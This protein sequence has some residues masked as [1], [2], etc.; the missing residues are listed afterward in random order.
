MFGDVMEN[1]SS[2]MKLMC[3]VVLSLGSC[4]FAYSL[5][6]QHGEAAGNQNTIMRMESIASSVR[7]SQLDWVA[8]ESNEASVPAAVSGRSDA[9]AAAGKAVKSLSPAVKGSAPR[10][11]QAPAARANGPQAVLELGM[12]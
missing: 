9:N 8:D 4:A 2:K 10:A 6:W 3:L 1:S 12:N 11:S 5:G 7:T